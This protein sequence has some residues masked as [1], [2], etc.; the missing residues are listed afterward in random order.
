MASAF[1]GLW[2]AERGDPK[3]HDWVD[4]WE[5]R[6][7]GKGR[8]KELLDDTQARYVDG[9]T[10][11]PTRIVLYIDQCEELYA[12]R[13][14]RQSMHRFSEI[15]AETLDDPRLLVLAS[16]RSDYY[17]DLQANAAL[18]PLTERVDV[19]PLGAK[20]LRVVLT[21]PA[22][23]LGAS[24]ESD[25]VV[26]LLVDAAKDQPGALPLL[27]DHMSELWSRMQARDDG[28]I[29][30]A[31]RS[32]LIQVSSALVK[33]AD[34]FLAE[35]A[36]DLETIKRLFCLQLAHV[37]REGEPVRRRARRSNCTDAEWSLIEQLS[38]ADWRLLVTGE[39]DGVAQAEIAHENPVARMA[40]ARS[41]AIG[42][43][44]VPRLARRDRACSPA[45]GDA[46]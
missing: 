38:G 39:V 6:L 7:I 5:A 46:A 1:T 29:R 19:A 8:L 32:E 21:E 45:G 25:G 33:R 31:D 41:V 27:A 23:S 30:I 34:Q 17:G 35:H 4:G 13:L 3:R 37:P 24:F 20:A 28:M 10:E 26:G 44:G 15:V 16:Q 36:A 40:D 43:T 11:P 9:K 22:R 2:F 12:S 42:A 18:F 14:P